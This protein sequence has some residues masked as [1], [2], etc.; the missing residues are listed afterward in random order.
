MARFD[1]R[2]SLTQR[3]H[4]HLMM[5][6]TVAGC[7]LVAAR[8]DAAPNIRITDNN[9]VPACVTPER[10]M[11]FLT[12]RNRRLNPKYREIAHLYR[13]WGEAWRVRWDYAFY[14][15]IIETNA[16]T[17]RRPD[18]RRGDVH[19]KQNNFAGIGATG[20]GVPGD[21]FPDVSTG[22][23]AQI[24]HL[25]TYSGVPVRQPIA[26]RTALVQD[27]IV[28]LSR[29]LGRPVTF[30][31]LAKRWAVDPAYW[32]SI[33]TLAT[34]FEQT[35]CGS[36]GRPSESAAMVAPKLSSAPAPVRARRRPLRSF[37]MP[38]RLG[39]PT[40]PK[41]IQAAAP[42]GEWTVAMAQQ[43]PV[44][45]LPWAITEPLTVATPAHTAPA[46]P[47]LTEETWTAPRP[48]PVRTLWSRDGGAVATRPA[49]AAAVAATQYEPAPASTSAS[50]STGA[51]F[52]SFATGGL[53]GDAGQDG[54][55]PAFSW[56][57][58]GP[59]KPEPSKL[60]GPV[61]DLTEP[62][63][64]NAAGAADALPWAEATV[65]RAGTPA[66][67]PTV[68]HTIAP[69]AMRPAGTLSS[70]MGGGDG[71]GEAVAKE[72]VVQK[73][74]MARPVPRAAAMLP[75]TDPVAEPAVLPVALPATPPAVASTQTP[76]CKIIEA[77]YG[78]KTTLL[79]SSQLDGV[80]RLIALTVVDGFE[81][82]MYETYA[83]AAAPG[84]DII[85]RY[86]NVDAALADAKSNC[87]NG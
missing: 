80:N 71:S 30:A 6:G 46:A 32:R 22:V 14:Q 50:K 8:A 75:V 76:T 43:A 65:T 73:S 72:T 1:A 9:R 52:F 49:P 74:A 42:A 38:S 82:A 70:T 57:S 86:D 11:A 34:G 45:Q 53:F 10:L 26:P 63:P 18:G 66:V 85:G 39:G 51:S 29:R 69:V 31:D 35:Y 24:Q 83:R 58:I 59:T 77:S 19:E 12:A 61:P 13:H 78:G 23:H 16:L 54:N 60:G 21:R 84:A 81:Q 3:N 41:Q 20:G 28:M 48:Y 4:R 68:T 64:Q 40:P 5:A 87:P 2:R 56:F 17:F 62:V 47:G 33:S 25:V 37:P 27:H 55:R 79:L 36:H 44:E 7:M 67:A 15:M